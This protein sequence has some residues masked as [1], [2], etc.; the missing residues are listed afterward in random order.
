MSAT[1]RLYLVPGMFGFKNLLGYEYFG[2]FRRELLRQFEAAGHKLDIDVITT[3]PTASVRHRARVLA[4]TLAHLCNDSD[5]PIHLL[6][7]STGGL[8]VRLLLSPNCNLGL[9]PKSL[10]W[11]EHVRSALT[12]NTP[13][14]GTPLA[15]YF[16][17]VAG[18]RALY[19]LSLLTVLSLSIGEPSLAL[20]SRVLAGVGS[21]DQLFGG[22]ARVFRRVTDTLLRYTDQGSRQALITYLNKLRADQGAL[23]QTTPEAMDLFNATITDNPRVRYGSV[24]TGSSPLALSQLGLRL[25]SPYGA[26]SASLY[27][28]IFRI[29]SEAHEFYDYCRLT[30]RD[31]ESLRRRLGFPL[32][33]KSS[34]GVVPT[35]SMVYADVVWAG[36]A[37]HL[38]VIG[39][40]QDSQRPTAHLDWMTSSAKFGR[41]E[42]TEMTAAIVAFQLQA[43][44]AAR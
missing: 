2:H 18:G 19:A 33:P 5:E 10:A 12:M 42:F 8:D 20:F 41:A 40:F 37:D 3:P 24:V 39:H 15:T 44:R 31:L 38:D 16:A 22:D 43:A 1:Q 29:T 21:F 14:Y 11:R 13:H 25:F 27:R 7:H 36:A 6:G 28:T 9:S 30:E 26:F 17:T 23:I 4:R 32:D 34:D 35:L